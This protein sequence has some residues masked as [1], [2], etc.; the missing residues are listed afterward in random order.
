MKTV[1]T[2]MAAVKAKEANPMLRDVIHASLI[3]SA[4]FLGTALAAD[5]VFSFTTINH[6]EATLT[7]AEG[8]SPEG[9]IGGLYADASGVTHGFVL[10][11]G[12]FTTVDYPGAAY[13]D[14]RATNP[15][16]DIVGNYR[17]PGENPGYAIHGFVL[18]RDGTFIPLAYPGY[19]YM[20][21]QRILPD[22]AVLGCVH[23]A[24]YVVMVGF[25]WSRGVYTGLDGSLDGLNVPQSMNNGATPD[26]GQIA[27]LFT[28]MQLKK[29]RA[30]VIQ[31][32]SFTPFDYPGASSTAAWDI[33]PPGAIVGNYQAATG[34][35]GFLLENGVFTSVQFPGAIVT[36]GRGINP[37]GAIVGSYRDATG[38]H[39]FLAIPMPG[40]GQ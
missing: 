16:G 32:G 24:G 15:A 33:N 2:M 25:V 23:N 3:G 17:L 14:V 28:D 29:G 7:V 13:T 19:A 12:I 26:L 8:I 10:R 39:G 21:A 4:L 31:N 38:T 30:Y 11:H 37:G 6:P 36:Q 40:H 5:P 22:G 34:T 27:G 1:G 35:H 9:Y 18:K 20:I